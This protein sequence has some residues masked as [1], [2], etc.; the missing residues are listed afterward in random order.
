MIPRDQEA[1]L[2]DPNEEIRRSRRFDE[3]GGFF[4]IINKLV[5][6]DIF[7]YSRRLKK[8]RDKNSRH[9]DPTDARSLG[10]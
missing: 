1:W 3:D 10:V 2:I 9:G 7:I 4:D 6:A 8:D 5:D